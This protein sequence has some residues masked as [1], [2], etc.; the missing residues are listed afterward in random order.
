[1]VRRFCPS[2]FDLLS[3][4]PPVVEPRFEQAHITNAEHLYA[5][6]CMAMS[7]VLR[8]A[9]AAGMQREAVA[10]TMSTFLEEEYTLDRLNADT[11][12]SRTTHIINAVRLFALIRAT[13]DPRIIQMIAEPIGYAVI[14]RKWLP[15]VEATI[16]ELQEAEIAERRRAA[17]DKARRALG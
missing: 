10:A 3:W 15:A 1:M 5:Q 12:Q 14:D 6:L 11:A 13:R 2:T 9:Q 7:Q 8:D 17:R 4:E 16:L